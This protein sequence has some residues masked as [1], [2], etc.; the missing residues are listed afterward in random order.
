[1]TTRL[2]TRH[3]VLGFLLGLAIVIAGFVLYGRLYREAS[4]P[5]FAT[6]EEHFLY[7]SV[8]TEREGVPFWIWLVLPRLFPEYL[9]GPGG[10]ASTGIV[11]R[12][13]H[14]MPIGL[15]KVTIGYPRVGINCALCHTASYRMR[16]G[17]APVIVPGAPA[18]QTAAQQYLRFLIM[19]A[20][21]P[22]FT[23]STILDEIAKNTRLSTVDRLLYR[24]VIIPGTRRSL[25]R[26]GSANAWMWER[27]DW[28]RGRADLFNPLKYGLKLPIDTTIGHTDTV[29]LFN[30]KQHAGYFLQWDGMSD[31]LQDV[32]IAS[33]LTA[34]APAKWVDRDFS[35]WNSTKPEEMSSLRR[36]ENYISGVQAP[37]YPFPINRAL[38]PAGETIYRRDCASC[39]APGGART[40]KVIP[41]AEVGTDRQRLDMWT[42]AAATAF[43]AFSAGHSWKFS[44]F[45]TTGG[46]VGVPLEGLWL[47]AP[48]LHNGSVPSLQDLLEKADQRPRAFR[49]GYDVY[50]PV[51][52]GFVSSGPEAD[53]VGTLFDT[54]VAGGGN[55]GHSYG[56]D[57]PA[58]DKAAL[59]EYLK[60]L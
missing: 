24:F 59:I 42:P 49:R 54:S 16:P 23:A 37:P 38:V 6:D 58:A 34:G 14:E 3:P 45:K 36:V 46:Y 19:A 33:A 40:G 26:L 41:A 10:Y 18:H 13:G 28:G 20:A 7:G 60:T 2:R 27:P 21:D 31:K 9:P 25:R 8:G 22:R 32:M 50:D 5:Y 30:L 44:E 48:Y 43:N 12:D 11:S 55:G 1:M 29:P 52:V 57:L 35:K 39:H 53:R 15:S 4:A 17:D 51:R 56:T 47:R